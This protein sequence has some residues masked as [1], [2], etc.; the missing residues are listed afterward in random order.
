MKTGEFIVWVSDD[1][2]AHKRSVD[3]KTVEADAIATTHELAIALKPRGGKEYGVMEIDFDVSVLVRAIKA[4]PDKD[5]R[6]QL[7]KF[8][9]A[10][11]EQFRLLLNWESRDKAA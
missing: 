1:A 2:G 3:L 8:S 7:A 6:H 10:Q 5:L 4:S 11:H 9:E